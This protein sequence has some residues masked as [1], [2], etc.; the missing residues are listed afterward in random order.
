MNECFLSSCQEPDVISAVA[1]MI[2]VHSCKFTSPLSSVPGEMLERVP[3]RRSLHPKHLL[4]EPPFPFPVHDLAVIRSS[5][6]TS[7]SMSG[8][9]AH[10]D[11]DDDS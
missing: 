1:D 10:D 4:P 3:R 2:E 9:D 7:T 8:S 5:L 11:R 6:L